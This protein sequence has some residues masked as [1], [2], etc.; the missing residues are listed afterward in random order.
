LDPLIKSQLLD[1]S[2]GDLLVAIVFY[3]RKFP[4]SCVIRTHE[5]P[6]QELGTSGEHPARIL[7]VTTFH[8]HAVFCRELPSDVLAERKK[9]L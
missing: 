8:V 9:S 1:W 5:I 6:V 4:G 3:S 7:H 2:E